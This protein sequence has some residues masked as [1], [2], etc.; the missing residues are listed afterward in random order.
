MNLPR[1]VRIL[2]L[3]EVLRKRTGPLLEIMFGGSKRRM[4]VG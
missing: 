3:K 1:K 4:I 2:L